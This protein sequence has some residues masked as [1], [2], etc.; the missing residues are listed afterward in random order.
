MDITKEYIVRV[1]KQVNPYDEPEEIDARAKHMHKWLQRTR[2]V[3]FSML[4][5]L[6]VL[7]DDYEQF[8]G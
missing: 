4:S 1:L 5:D 7:L 8:D 2:I 3:S 6:I